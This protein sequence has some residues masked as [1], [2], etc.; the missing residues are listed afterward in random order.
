MIAKA[1][2]GLGTLLVRGFD[3]LIDEQGRAEHESRL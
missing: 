3:P 2:S 1:F